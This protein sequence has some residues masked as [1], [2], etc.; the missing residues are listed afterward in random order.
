[1]LEK[2][3]TLSIIKFNFTFYCI[4][5]N[6]VQENSFVVKF[7]STRPF[8]SYSNAICI[9]EKKTKVYKDVDLAFYRW[10]PF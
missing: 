2:N 4:L 1:M 8:E 10:K 9:A 3:C 6:K 5:E 7:A